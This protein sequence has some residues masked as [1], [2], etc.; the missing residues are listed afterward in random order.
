MRRQMLVLA[1]FGW[2]CSDDKNDSSGGSDGD[3]DTDTDSDTDTDADTDSDTDADTDFFFDAK[4][5]FDGTPFELECP[6]DLMLGLR[7]DKGGMSAVAASCATLAEGFMVVVLALD[8]HIGDYT[9][10]SYNAAIQ[11]GNFDS[12]LYYDCLGGGASNFQMSITEVDEAP[13]STVWGATFSMTGDDGTHSG[14]VSG[15]FRM[16]SPLTK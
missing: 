2:S 15:S 11:V 12:G 14:E 8:P 3:A 5:T 1:L 9:D 4:G 16:E 13:K 10:C 7:E 6:P